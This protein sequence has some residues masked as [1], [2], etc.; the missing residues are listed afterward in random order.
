MQQKH[1]YDEAPFTDRFKVNVLLEENVECRLIDNR[2]YVDF[3]WHNK[4]LDRGYM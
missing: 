4:Q 1:R 2:S 3:I